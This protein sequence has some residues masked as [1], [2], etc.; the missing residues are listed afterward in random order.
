M[1]WIRSIN[2]DGIAN[3]TL[4][5]TR[6]LLKNDDQYILL[7]ESKEIANFIEN[8]I[9]INLK[10]NFYYLNC[11]VTSL[12]NIYLLP[13][14]IKKLKPDL[15]FSP[16]YS[17]FSPFIT[18]K[19]IGVVHDLIPLIFPEMFKKSSLKFKL[20]YANTFVL[21]KILSYLDKVITVSNSTKNDLIKYL[22]IGTDKIKVIVEGVNVI[23]LDENRLSEINKQYNMN[24]EYFLFIGRHEKYKNIDGL[25]KVYYQLPND[26]QEKYNLIIIGK[27]NVNFTPKLINMI[28]NFKL[29]ENI[30]LIESVTPNNLP[31]FYKK[32]KI[33][34]HLS[35]Y[36]GFGLTVL[37]AMS[38]GLPVIVSDRASMI[39]VAGD[40]CINVNP[41]NH[42]IVVD[43]LLEV[44][45]ND[46]LYKSLSVKGLERAKKFTW[47]QS[48][49]EIQ[50]IFYS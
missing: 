33:L 36:E 39:E 12:K 7:V 34:I 18:C 44:L 4:N 20:S 8:N 27:Y 15:F 2:I 37:E 6:E 26:I 25:I 16:C 28:E 43:K 10:D 45:N 50:E 17:L 11:S 47:I 42:S 23:D 14:I 32:A 31:Y 5:T 30:I 29:K 21:K 13:K 49:K 3:F 46:T 40:A 1:R 19:Q 9:S 35:L 41:D 48:A 22:N 24:K 38:Y